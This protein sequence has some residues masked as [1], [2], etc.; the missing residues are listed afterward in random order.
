M[1]LDARSYLRFLVRD[2]IGEQHG[3]CG[4][5]F[6]ELFWKAGTWHDAAITQQSNVSSVHRV[7]VCGDCL[8]HDD[9]IVVAVGNEETSLDELPPMSG[10]FKEVW[11]P[12]HRVLRFVR[13]ARREKKDFM[14]Q[15]HVT[16]PSSLEECQ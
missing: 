4:K 10:E 2:P 9:E 14:S 15:C 13:N 1:K 12:Y 11:D 6:L 3:R 7:Q 5:F 8:T 16:I